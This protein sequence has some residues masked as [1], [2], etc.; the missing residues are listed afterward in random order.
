MAGQSSAIE[1][2]WAAHEATLIVVGTMHP[3]PTFPWFDGWHLT[4][5]IAVDEVLYGHLASREIKFRLVCNCPCD[6]WPPLRLPRQFMEKGLWFLR[7]VDQ[8]TWESSLRDCHYIGFGSLSQR[9]DFEHY[10]R[11]YKQ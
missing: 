11:L 6:P 5:T 8:L 10:I 4:G 3:G 1:K 7:P 9:S 2:Y